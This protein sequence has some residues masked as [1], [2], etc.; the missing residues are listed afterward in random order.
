MRSATGNRCGPEPKA[1][2]GRE[3]PK[4]QYVVVGPPGGTVAAAF[5]LTSVLLG[6]KGSLR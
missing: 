4:A 1:A 3:G 5:F 6:E 2:G